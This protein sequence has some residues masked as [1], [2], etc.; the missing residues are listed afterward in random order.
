MGWTPTKECL[1]NIKKMGAGARV[2]DDP[3]THC[4]DT[5]DYTHKVCKCQPPFE[6]SGQCPYG[7]NSP[8]PSYDN[9]G[10]C[11]CCCSCFA[12]GTLIAVDN[13]H[14][15]VVEEFVPGDLVYAASVDPAT[16]NLTWKVMP[17]EFSQGT[18]DLA[19]QS[20][21]VMV[22]FQPEGKDEDYLIVTKN[23]LFY[24]PDGVLKRADTLVP[25]LDIL[26]MADGTKA[27]VTGIST[28]TF[29]KG[30]HHIATSLTPALNVDGHLINAKGV[31]CGDYAL[32]ISDIGRGDMN[33]E[34]AL[35]VFGTKAYLERYSQY[36]TG[37]NFR[38]M[39][40]ARVAS[41][42]SELTSTDGF[43][44]LR[45]R[46]ESGIP[47]DAQHYFSR[48]QAHDIYENPEATRQPPSSNVGIDMTNYLFKLYKGFYPDIHF[49]LNLEN[50]T[51]NAYSFR[52][53]GM[54]IVEVA[55]G[56]VHLD[57]VQFESLAVIIAHEIG[58]LTGGEPLNSA[59]YS[60]EGQADYVG[61]GAVIRTVWYGKFFG[62]IMEPALLQLQNIFNLIVPEID[63]EGIPGNT[64]MYI[65][66]DCRMKAMTSAM[67]SMP[68][69]EC[70]G[71]P[72]EP[73]LEVT[74]AE[75][76]SGEEVVVSF[77]V[78]VDKATAEEKKNY[79]L[80]PYALVTKA[81]AD[82]EDPSKVRLTT[83]LEANVLYNLKV[84]N[85][86]SAD[87]HPLITS[88]STATF[89]WVGVIPPE[90]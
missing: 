59:G 65:S 61:V 56:L 3:Y 72:K 8:I 82:E 36:I 22:M 16:N 77:N 54:K 4:E 19:K 88:K 17:V 73:F 57:A 53:H 47:D 40:T 66:T 60:C 55:V 30:V 13:T 86:L 9:K 89:E 37:D 67:R 70:A 28:G 45:A 90:A 34:Q 64:C 48:K 78:A 25:G 87:G 29:Q 15:K 31:V 6:V 49:Y 44:H 81:V 85:L 71:G 80:K 20:L 42:S 62:E 11:Y 68:L 26:L 52:E 10:M 38:A 50:E 76:V 39:S 7:P 41:N 2:C 24:M 69:P 51:I 35:P 83:T 12:F 58:H 32:Q 14:Y 18:G 33:A 84:V 23:Q 5:E 46:G 43:T 1:D 27:P 21:M 74:G 63:R 75:A 79:I